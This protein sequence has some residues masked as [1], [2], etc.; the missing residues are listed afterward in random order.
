MRDAIIPARAWTML[1]TSRQRA[2]GALQRPPS[3]PGRSAA[4]QDPVRRQRARRGTSDTDRTGRRPCQPARGGGARYVHGPGR[5]NCGSSVRHCTTYCVLTALASQNSTSRGNMDRRVRHRTARTRTARPAPVAACWARCRR[6]N[7]LARPRCRASSLR[8]G[9]TGRGRRHR[10]SMADVPSH[11][12]VWI[13]R[14]ARVLIHRRPV[15]SCGPRRSRAWTSRWWRGHHHSARHR[16]WVAQR[17]ARNASALRR[18]RV[19]GTRGRWRDRV[20]RW[21]ATASS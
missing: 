5:Q 10:W 6:V 12:H 13:A 15:R 2:P 17:G 4:V 11:G 8:C 1:R 16:R 14:P 7:R 21:R 3:R 19:C 20:R 18:D 9:R